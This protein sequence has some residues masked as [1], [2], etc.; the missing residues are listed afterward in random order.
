M[1]QYLLCLLLLILLLCLGA[2]AQEYSYH[3][4]TTKDGLA[5]E[6]V[7][8]IT[9]D[10][11]G[12]LWIGTEAGLSR[13]DGQKFQNFSTADGLPSREIF[14]CTED[15]EHRLWIISYSRH[16]CYYKEGKIY[17]RFN[18]SLLKKIIFNR[19]IT[20]ILEDP[21]QRILIHDVLGNMYIIN[22]NGTVEWHPSGSYQLDYRLLLV[23][24]ELYIPQVNLPV[25]MR[26]AVHQYFSALGIQEKSISIMKLAEDILLFKAYGRALIWN[27]TEERFI[28]MSYG[29][30]TRFFKLLANGYLPASPVGATGAFLYD[31]RSGVKKTVF[32]NDYIVNDIYQD[33]EDNVWFS[34]KGNGLFRL[35]RTTVQDVPL[36]NKALPISFVQGD[37]N[38]IW[39]GTENGEC[40]QISPSPAAEGHTRSGYEQK[41]FPLSK[42]WLKEHAGYA[43]LRMHHSLFI[44]DSIGHIKST[45]A[46]DGGMLVASTHGAYV[47]RL[48]PDG[49]Y[50]MKR[51]YHRTTAAIKYGAYYYLGTLEGLVIM[52]EQYNVISRHL[53]CPINNIMPGPNGIVWLATHGNGVFGIKDHKV[54]VQINEA[55]SGLSSDLCTYIYASEQDLW[56]ATNKGLNQVALEEGRPPKVKRLF[57]AT[58][59][60]SSDEVTAVF[61]QDTA[62]WVGTRKGLNLI[63]KGGKYTPPV[64]GLYF[65]GITLAGKILSF[66]E[67]I[68]ITHGQNRIRFDFSATLFSGEKIM[69]SYRVLGLNSN[70]VETEE[71]S[72]SFLSLPSGEYTLEVKAVSALGQESAV[73][74]KKF[75]VERAFYETWW[76]R[77]GAL[78]VFGSLIYLFLRYRIRKIRRQEE[79]KS[80]LNRK[81]TELEQMALRAQ[82]NPHFIFNCLNSVQ[83]YIVRNDSMGAS[84]YLSRF[85]TLIRKTLDNAGSL[86][87]PLKEELA[88]LESYIELEQLQANH[89]FIYTIQ[90]SSSINTSTTAFPNMILQPFVENAIKHGMQY[91]GL[92]AR[93]MINFTLKEDKSIVCCIEDNGPGIQ[94][95]KRVITAHHS[96]GM[97]ITTQ[98]VAT[99]NELNNT[100]APIAVE[101]EDLAVTG[102]TGTRIMITVP[103]KNL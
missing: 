44:N 79:E 48:L 86:Y 17:N 10:H 15:S 76:F 55:N 25:T 92:D 5:A 88:Y 53:S 35:D 6:T 75:N 45:Y 36:G 30:N 42:K 40:W 7:Y 3:Q 60:L 33:R 14:G 46:Y 22:R 81:M 52:D 59:G 61:V 91:A 37:N 54:V 97:Q 100:V 41:Q 2:S 49:S 83:N 16:L 73:I 12:F 102:A 101:V 71:T 67:P 20:A 82:M 19:E 4:Y 28:E 1:K 8:D 68:S 13:F 21:S 62:I 51:I 47:C 84:M 50:S 39:V 32:F 9:Q 77:G 56:I 80:E 43:P 66:N 11:Q 72:L 57:T 65:T 78:L 64:I 98:R 29:K 103:L 85:A 18:D 87:L 74:Q 34:T 96:K 31:C 38:G 63:A 69:Y 26:Q 58:N 23:G 70:W 99:L 27:A 89:P 24:G 94:A 93:L 95:A 90:V